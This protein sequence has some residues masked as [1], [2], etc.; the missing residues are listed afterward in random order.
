MQV[1]KLTFK[2]LKKS[3]PIVMISF[4]AFTLM[5]VAVGY[6]PNKS[7]SDSISQVKI[8][9]VNEDIDTNITKA[10]EDILLDVA[11]IIEIESDKVSIQT[12]LYYQKVDCVLI[13][14]K[15]Y[16]DSFFSSDS[17]TLEK[18]T[19]P[20]SFAAVQVET[21]VN[22]FTKI[23]TAY[24]NS[25]ISNDTSIKMAISDTML[26]SN[27]QVVGTAKSN[28]LLSLNMFLGYAMLALFINFTYIFTIP[29]IAVSK[30]NLKHRQS[31]AP[32]SSKNMSFQ[33]Y[34]ACFVLSLGSIALFV[35]IGFIVF[36]IAISMQAVWMVITLLAMSICLMGISFLIGTICKSVNTTTFIAMPLSMLF[37]FSSGVFIPKQFLDSGFIALGKILPSWLYTSNLDIAYSNSVFTSANISEMLLN[38]G[39]ILT[40]AVTFVLIA[41]VIQKYKRVER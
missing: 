10:I 41:I 12:A 2:L 28:N 18:M 17:I 24:N 4:F 29:M 30:S 14:P 1:F 31:C 39:I 37:C 13:I 20:G 40:F 16:S 19:I 11:E 25:G 9:I 5:A 23:A 6:Q 26:N 22:T 32:I 38:I 21:R 34:L 35:L 15:G 33:L 3:L 8:A 36:D 7:V 27:T